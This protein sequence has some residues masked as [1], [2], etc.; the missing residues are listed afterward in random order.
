MIVHLLRALPSP[1]HNFFKKAN[2]IIYKFI[3][4]NKPDKI[5]RSVLIN[6]YSAG[7]TNL[8]HLESFAKSMKIFWVKKILNDTYNTEWKTLIL[9]KIQIWRKLH[10][11]LPFRIY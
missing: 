7:G 9:D 3:W 6:D 8:I 4:D 5:K 2:N 11:A 1:D 10:L